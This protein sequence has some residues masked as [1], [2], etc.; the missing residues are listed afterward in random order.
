MTGCTYTTPNLYGITLC[1]LIHLDTVQSCAAALLCSGTG[2][3]LKGT[4]LHVTASTRV[5]AGEGRALK[6]YHLRT[7]ALA[8]GGCSSKGCGKQALHL[9][10]ES[11]L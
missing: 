4:L 5:R 11:A 6:A 2:A 9:R 8:F 7:F 3:F 10:A 1:Y